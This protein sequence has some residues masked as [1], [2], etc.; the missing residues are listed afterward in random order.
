MGNITAGGGAAPVDRRERFRYGIVFLLT[1][2]L[3]VFVIAAPSADWSHAVA[4]AIEGIALVV[5]NRHRTRAQAAALPHGCGRGR[6][7]G[8]GRRR[9]R[10]RDRDRDHPTHELTYMVGV[11][12]TAAVPIVIFRGLLRL[13]RERGVTVQAVAG[14][15]AV[16]LSVG[17]AFAWIIAF[18][19]QVDATPISRSTR[20]SPWETSSTSASP[21]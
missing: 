6:C 11:L 20:T 19:A 5:A 21:C 14:A 9:R 16:Y 18:I 1:L 8:L 15:L 7:D 13:L 4:L 3:V 12:A 17:L 2:A 10:D